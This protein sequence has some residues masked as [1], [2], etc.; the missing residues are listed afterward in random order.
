MPTYEDLVELANIC[1]RH[2]RAAADKEVAINFTATSRSTLVSG[3][4]VRKIAPLAF[5]S[6]ITYLLYAPW[7]FY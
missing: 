6:T 5:S 2:A 4:A 7:D 3:C 1:A